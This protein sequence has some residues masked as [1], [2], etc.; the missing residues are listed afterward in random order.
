MATTRPGLPAG[1]T[2]EKAVE[3]RRAERY[4]LELPARV[5]GTDRAGTPFQEESVLIDLSSRGA[6]LPLV[7][8]QAPGSRL[9]VSI[10]LP[11]ANSTWMEYCATVVRVEREGLSGRVGLEFQCPRPRFIRK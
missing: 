6:S 2:E 7:T 1:Q 11:F 8:D 10:R 3:R 9:T 5:Q 4:K